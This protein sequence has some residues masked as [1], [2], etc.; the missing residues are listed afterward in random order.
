[1]KSHMTIAVN[2]TCEVSHGYCCEYLIGGGTIVR[3]TL[4]DDR[5]PKTLLKIS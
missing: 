3:K 5:Q 1:M 2:I 4:L